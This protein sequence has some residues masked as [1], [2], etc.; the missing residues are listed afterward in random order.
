MTDWGEWVGRHMALHGYDTSDP[1]E[2]EQLLLWAEVFAREGF[3]PGDLVE[4]SE[5]LVV[6]GAP[7]YR[8][9]MLEALQRA[10]QA[11]RDAR[12]ADRTARVLG[13]L[14]AASAGRERACHLCEGAGRVVVPHPLTVVEG[15]WRPDLPPAVVVDGEVLPGQLLTQGTLAVLCRCPLGQ[16]YHDR[17]RDRK[18]PPWTLDEYEDR[19]PDWCRLVAE[20]RRASRALGSARSGARMLDRVKGEIRGLAARSRVPD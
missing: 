4:A 6:S 3:R 15:A 20:R 2:A 14:Q 17:Q 18:P 19:V 9:A 13:T 1:A 16:W 5:R 7:R 11:C 8:G 12:K 10:L